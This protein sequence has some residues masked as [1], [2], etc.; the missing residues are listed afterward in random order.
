MYF[1]GLI[2]FDD[3]GRLYINH[4]C[5]SCMKFPLEDLNEPCIECN[6]SKL[7]LIKLEGKIDRAN[8]AIDLMGKSF[9]ENDGEEIDVREAFVHISEIK[10]GGSGMDKMILQDIDMTDE[11]RG[12]ADLAEHM[13][14][15]IIYPTNIR[16]VEGDDYDDD[17]YEEVM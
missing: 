7:A 3:N 15:V 4:E 17:G 11:I 9:T 6:Y 12:M 16:H 10:L 2:Q 1:D 8:R 14:R 5:E 13:V